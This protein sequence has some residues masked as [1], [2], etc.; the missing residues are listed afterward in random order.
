MISVEDAKNIILKS[1]NKLNSENVD[2]IDSLDRISFE[3]I[4]WG[5]LSDNAIFFHL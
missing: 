2:L 5:F 4:F 1:T 3:D